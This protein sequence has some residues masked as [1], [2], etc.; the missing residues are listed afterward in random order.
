M[1]RYFGYHSD[2][3]PCVDYQTRCLRYAI[4]NSWRQLSYPRVI[5]VFP[6]DED[7]PQYP[8]GSG[9]VIP[10]YYRAKTCVLARWCSG[11]VRGGNERRAWLALIIVV[12]WDWLMRTW[13]FVT[14]WWS[15]DV[16]TNS[17]RNELHSEKIRNRTDRIELNGHAHNALWCVHERNGGQK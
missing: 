13:A 2:W 12:P 15:T 11:C 3:H 17:Y 4:T 10:K 6:S 16:S 5:T 1:S 14:D 8:Q 7:H 9:V